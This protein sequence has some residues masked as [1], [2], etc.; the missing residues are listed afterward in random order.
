MRKDPTRAKAPS[1][2]CNYIV[3][4]NIKKY[5]KKYKAKYFYFDLFLKLFIEK[6]NI[7]QLIKEKTF[8]IFVTN[9]GS[10]EESIR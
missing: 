2:R 8:L 9:I 7:L 6:K 4:I 1:F 5:K 10:G 3:T